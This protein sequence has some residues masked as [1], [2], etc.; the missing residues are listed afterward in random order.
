MAKD[1]YALTASD[2]AHLR[3]LLHYAR[4]AVANPR[5][6]PVPREEDS[7][8][9]DVFVALTPSE[10]IAG[11]ELNSPGTGTTDLA[12]NVVH[13]AEC[14][15]Y[16]LRE[17]EGTAGEGILQRAE[18]T[19]LVYNHSQADLPG[20]TFV[21]IMRDKAGRWWAA[22]V[23]DAVSEPGT[24]DAGGECG[25]TGLETDDCILVRTDKGDF[26]LESD[27]AG[28]WTGNGVY[29]YGGVGTGTTAGSFVFWYEAGRTHLS[30]DGKELLSCGD[31]CF[32]GGAL[33]GHGSQGTGTGPEGNTGTGQQQ[34]HCTGD[35]FTVCV[36]CTCCL[37]TA[38]YCVDLG[39]GCEPVY[40]SNTEACDA[41]TVI[42]SG[43]YDSYALAAAACPAVTPILMTGT[44]CCTGQFINSIL[45]AH[46][47]PSGSQCSELGA[48]FDITMTWRA[49]VDTNWSSG[50]LWEGTG[51][52]P[53]SGGIPI[54][55]RFGCY[56][57]GG[58][59]QFTIIYD[60]GCQ[61]NAGISPLTADCP[62]QTWSGSFGN[63]LVR[64]GCA[65][66]GYSVAVH[67]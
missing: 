52:W 26:L 8:A 17:A 39:D 48:G 19:R 55:V 4:N 51:T 36:Q 2:V 1:I 28:T 57:L 66:W 54:T 7:Q 56:K 67:A 15:V 31:G 23:A 41:S 9:P 29:D 12:D 58:A 49:D 27:G 47:G 40:L 20:N 50:G 60:N 14:V 33:T 18:L 30:L 46:I 64:C 32:S 37:P 65:T 13:G 10:G 53:L 3:E 62:G 35:Y 61:P 25:L 21:R 6:R 22:G 45:H 34:T 44:N 38:W 11:L 43:P 24:G 42:C 63:G 59:W 5:L 16:F